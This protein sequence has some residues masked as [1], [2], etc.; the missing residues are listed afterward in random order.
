MGLFKEVRKPV[1][2]V[3][4]AGV[5]EISPL[6]PLFVAKSAPCSSGCPN[7]N[8]I[9]DLL[10]MIAQAKDYGLT[11]EQA[12]EKAWNRIVERNPLP[13]ITG[14]VC[15]HPCEDACN[16][17]AKDGAVAFHEIERML[18]DF[19]IARKLKL[20]RITS[21]ARP[22]KIAVV[23]AGPAGLSC[24]YQLAR[25]GYGVTIFESL[26]LPGGLLRYGIPEFRLQ[27]DVLEAEIGRILRLG[28]ELRCNCRIGRDISL[29]Q[30]RGDY[31]AVFVG[32]GAWKAM[33]LHVPGESASNVMGAVDFLRR[34]NAHED[35]ELGRKV[36]VVGAGLTAIDVAYIAQG[37][38][39][40][41]TMVAAEITAD[42]AEITALQEKGARVEAPAVP[43][44]MIAKDG[45]TKAV[46][47]AY[48]SGTGAEPIEFDLDA[49]FV[50]VA[51]NREPDLHGFE[52]VSDGHS[53]F[54]VDNFGRAGAGLFA[55]GDGTGLST[56][57]GAIAQ[58]RLAAETMDREFHGL[59]PEKPIPVPVM[60]PDKMKLD[61]YQA[62]PRRLPTNGTGHLSDPI[63]ATGRNEEALVN[64]A[65]RC[66]SCGMC[67]DCETCWMY[68]SNN[69][70]VRLPKGQHSSIKIE[71]CN[72]CKKCAEACP[73]GYIELF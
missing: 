25:R 43:V 33:P 32:T 47:S 48:L 57:T 20:P 70:F 38:S 15:P 45:R 18:G 39:A 40:H 42:K 27:R 19:G 5:G 21:D 24:A 51:T 65:K 72:G 10:V 73:S 13:A 66:M 41:V 36:V 62:A 61:W 54:R 7:G 71:L 26:S 60:T 11:T 67:M 55:G 8:Q 16:R 50:I 64:E 35:I 3:A 58:G 46:R 12:F 17:N 68:C 37:R 59:E 53:W 63:H 29:E 49:D 56:V 2:K 14:R 52:R 28:I 9:R 6:R 69:C 44:A 1:I 23:G 4:P 30:L 22:Q 31:N 34:V